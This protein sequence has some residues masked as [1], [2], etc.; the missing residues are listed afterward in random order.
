MEMF[1][2]LNGKILIIG[3]GGFI[4][5]MK[6]SLKDINANVEIVDELQVNNLVLFNHI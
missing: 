2:K 3:G 6:I 1:K 4:G 5:I